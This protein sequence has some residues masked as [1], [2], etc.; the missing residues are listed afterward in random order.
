M[1]ESWTAR[2]HFFFPMAAV[3]HIHED[4]YIW[5]EFYSS[6][7][8]CPRGMD[9][10]VIGF[11]NKLPLGYK[12]SL[13]SVVVSSPKSWKVIHLTLD[14][15]LNQSTARQWMVGITCCSSCITRPLTIES[16]SCRFP[17][18]VY[19]FH[20][21]M[22]VSINALLLYGFSVSSRQRRRRLVT[23]TL[24][25]R[26]RK[27]QFRSSLN[28]QKSWWSSE[29]WTN[30]SNAALILCYSKCKLVSQNYF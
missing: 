18:S 7:L 29:N 4:Y 17:D 19:P 20:Q 27:R 14:C 1:A 15:P 13:P 24:C 6:P 10:A 11:L 9:D 2:S 25:E 12:W 3:L 21:W 30:C 23:N 26:E 28:F 22:T 16:S 5:Y 8:K